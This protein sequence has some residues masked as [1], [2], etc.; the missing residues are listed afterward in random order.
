MPMRRAHEFT[1]ISNK[2]MAKSARAMEERKCQTSWR[3]K[4][5]KTQGALASWLSAGVTPGST[6][7][8]FSLKQMIAKAPTTK[9]IAQ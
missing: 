7:A 4:M 1:R 5:A 2:S 9:R 6:I 8:T 3:S